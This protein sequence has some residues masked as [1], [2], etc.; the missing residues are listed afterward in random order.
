M[1]NRFLIS[2]EYKVECNH[3]LTVIVS[4]IKELKVVKKDEGKFVTNNK[5]C[6][7]F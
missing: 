4:K 6:I 1:K 5:Q 2:C 7:T 3:E